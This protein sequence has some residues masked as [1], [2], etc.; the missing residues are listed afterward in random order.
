MYADAVTNQPNLAN[1]QNIRTQSCKTLTSL[2]CSIVQLSAYLDW[3]LIDPGRLFGT[4]ALV[5][6]FPQILGAY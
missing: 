5:K 4:C 3:H 1:L 6:I 2:A